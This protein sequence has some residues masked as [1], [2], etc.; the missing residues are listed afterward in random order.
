MRLILLVFMALSA[1]VCGARPAAA[2]EARPWHRYLWPPAYDAIDWE[3]R[4][5]QNGTT[6]HPDQWD[7]SGWKPEHWM[8]QRGGQGAGMVEHF[9]TVGILEDQSMEDDIPVL[10]VGTEFFRIG[11]EDQRRVMALVDRVYGV[12]TKSPHRMF[13]IEDGETGRPLGT[14][15]VSGLTLQ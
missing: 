9:F 7:A 13:L 12:T 3:R 10:E 8:A 15:T 1:I 4:L 14:Y 6:P 5:M 2:S 11:G